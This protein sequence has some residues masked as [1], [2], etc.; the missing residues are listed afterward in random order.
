MANEFDTLLT[1]TASEFTDVFAEDVTYWPRA[2]GSRAIKAIVSRQ[3]PE[4]LP[5]E[6]RAHGMTIT[7]TV[8]NN[9]TSGISSSEV[10]TGGDKIEL[11]RRIGETPIKRAINKILNQDAGMMELELR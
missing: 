6:A 3:T 9:A 7:V 10:D 1:E 5:G 8:E 2:G 4:Q 11:A